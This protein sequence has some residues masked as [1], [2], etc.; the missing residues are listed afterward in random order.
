MRVA[1]IDLVLAV[2]GSSPQVVARIHT[3][4]LPGGAGAALGA[5]WVAGL[6]HARRPGGRSGSRPPTIG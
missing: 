3:G 5:V 6:A 4:A 2:A 1:A